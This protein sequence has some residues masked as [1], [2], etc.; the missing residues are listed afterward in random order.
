MGT[1]CTLFVAGYLADSSWGWPSIFYATGLSAIIWSLLWFF[2]GANSP[3]THKNISQ[4]ERE[5]I[6]SLLVNSSLDSHVS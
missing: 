4:K 6:Q 5:Y 1:V 3:A 2:V